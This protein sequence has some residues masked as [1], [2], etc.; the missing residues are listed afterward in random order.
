MSYHLLNNPVSRLGG[1]VRRKQ[2]KYTF[3]LPSVDQVLR[4][5]KS[6]KLSGF[7]KREGSHSLSPSLHLKGKCLKLFFWAIR[8]GEKIVS[9]E[10]L[11]VEKQF[12][13][14]CINP[15][16][17]IN[18]ILFLWL[19]TGV[20]TGR[21]S[22]PGVGTYTF[23]SNLQLRGPLDETVWYVCHSHTAYRTY[24]QVKVRI[25]ASWDYAN[26]SLFVSINKTNA[27]LCAVDV[28]EIHLH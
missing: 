7:Q 2:T 17:K 26:N 11:Q 23:H 18:W 24:G 19:H 16:A 21:S 27:E 6:K 13:P 3:R 8:N 9:H 1:E 14:S 5:L 25:V 20:Y 28:G 22:D 4:H 12:L 10:V 15:E